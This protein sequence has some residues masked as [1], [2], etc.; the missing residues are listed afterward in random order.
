ML[1]AVFLVAINDIAARGTCILRSR[2]LCFAD[3]DADHVRYPASP[4]GSASTMT[5]KRTS[6]EQNSHLGTHQAED[7]DNCHSGPNVI[8]GPV[9]VTLLDRPVRKDTSG[10]SGL[11]D[12]RLDSGEFQNLGD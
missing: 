9:C 5:C 7:D 4:P 1:S 6:A 3:P 12:E 10:G 2:S 11:D 8:D